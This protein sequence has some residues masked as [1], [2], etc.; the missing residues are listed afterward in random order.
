VRGMTLNDAHIFVRPDQIKEEFK[1]VVELVQEV[2]KDFGF[3]NYS[4]RLSYRDPED[5]EKYFDDDE[6]WNK[7]E[8]MLKEAVDEMN[9]PYEEAVGEAAFYGP[10]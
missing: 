4:F 3:E 1:R 5:T 6:M 9:L 7:A 8:A 10:K 2:Y